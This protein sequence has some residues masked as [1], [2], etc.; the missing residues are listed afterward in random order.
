MTNVQHED[1]KKGLHRSLKIFC[2][3]NQVKTKRKRPKIIQ[4]VNAELSQIVG[5]MQSSYWME[6]ILPSS[7]V[8]RIFE[9][10]GGAGNLRIMQ[11]K[12]KISP[13]RISSFFRPKLGEDQKQNKKQKKVFT[14]I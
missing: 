10:V 2:P 11:T 14:Q 8:R 6:Y 4:H 12:R 9:R 5:G 3:R 7:G 13:R 1:Q